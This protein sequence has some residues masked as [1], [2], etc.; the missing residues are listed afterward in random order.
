MRKKCI[1]GNW[2]MNKT[3]QEALQ[4]ARALKM[5]ST[6]IRK[7][8]IG[9]CPAFLAI[10]AVADILKESRIMVGA[11][12]LYINKNGAFTGEIS[13]PMI[14][15]AG[16]TLVI[17]G[18]SERRQYF[19]ET[20][21]LVNKKIGFAMD[22]GLKPI[23]CIGETLE[24]RENGKM[25]SVIEKQYTGAMKDIPET[26]AKDI[27]IAYEPVWAIGTGR[28]ATVQ[29]ADEVHR[30]IRRLAEKIY[31]SAFAESMIIQ[32]G[33]SVKADNAKDLFSSPNIDGALVGGAS[34]D[35]DGFLA[36]VRA[37]ESIN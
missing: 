23:V 27:I 30:M 35:P 9:V 24:E 32:Y 19:Q 20:D 33:G 10:P 5:K 3:P 29:Q 14:K 36:I 25:E 1:V 22:E 37:A 11:Q 21:E 4:L 26:R 6:D 18:H 34:L 16:C 8:D 13:A 17:I 15:D 28:N 31:S 12:N 2:K 7:T